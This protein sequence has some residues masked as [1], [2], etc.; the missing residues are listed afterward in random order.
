MTR[1]W[2][3]A[4]ATAS[5]LECTCS[6]SYNRA[7]V[8]AHGVHADPEF[9]RR[10][11]VLTAVTEV[12]SRRIPAHQCGLRTPPPSGR[13]SS[14]AS[15]WRSIAPFIDLSSTITMRFSRPASIPSCHV[16]D[17]RVRKTPVRAPSGNAYCERL[18]GIIRRECLDFLSESSRSGDGQTPL[19]D[20]ESRN[21]PEP[22]VR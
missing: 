20:L 16:L 3:S 14:S 11:L 21:R 6:F 22:R 5:G 8:K 10:V 17:A 13:F 7:Q 2:R 18:V 4:R 9:R 12:G 19:W 15:L 1:P